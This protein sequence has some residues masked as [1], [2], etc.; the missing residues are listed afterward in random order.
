MSLPRYPNYKDSGVEW[1]GEVPGHWE[2]SSLKRSF[3][4][5]GGSTPKSDIESYWDGD[6]LWATPSDLSNRESIYLDKTLRTISDDGLASCGT[7]LVPNGSIILS[8]R[9]PIGSLAIAAVSM[10]TNQGCKSL[11]P[12]DDADVSYFAHLLSISSTELNLRGKGTTFLELS[13]D[14]LGA[15]KTPAPPLAEQIQIAAFL[16][17][18][19]AKIDELVAEQRRLME[20][21]KEKRQAVISHTVTRGL[22][23][24]V[25]LKPSGIEWLGDVPE[26]WETRSIAKASTKITNGFVGPTRDILVSQGVPYIQA[27]HIKSGCVN[28]DDGYFV[29]QEWSDAHAKSILAEGDSLIVQT[30]AGTGDVGLVS[31]AEVGFNCHALIIVAPDKSLILG[32]FLAAV[33]QSS[34][35]QQKLSSI[36]TGAM[37]PHLNC[38]EVKFVEVPLPPL[39][40]QDEIVAYINAAAGKFDTLTTETQRAIDLLQERRTALISAAVTGQVDVRGLTS[41]EE[42]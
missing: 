4:I 32:T 9:A 39:G 35:G 19:T 29:T 7:T 42:S 21:L 6:I 17:R 15:F 1:L 30:G 25:R 20:L 2:V 28:F 12:V 13:T 41:S 16:D 3:Q 31:A 5:V 11:V 18:E 14:E 36:R 10:C 22:N 33:L 38:G 24:D 37:H 40:E 27:T 34:Y 23:P 8:T 26:H